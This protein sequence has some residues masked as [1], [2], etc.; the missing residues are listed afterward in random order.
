MFVKFLSLEGYD[1]EKEESFTD[2]DYNPTWSDIEDAICHMEIN[3]VNGLYLWAEADEEDC[4]TIGG[5]QFGKFIVEV[6]D[7]KRGMYYLINSSNS[8]SDE[9]ISLMACTQLGTYPL[10]I[11]VD[12]DTVIKA[13]KTYAELGICDPSLD[14]EKV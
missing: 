2:N 13:A 1:S 14:W 10:Q 6:N 11:C 9:K 7:T 5:G 4:M 12:L 8:K 3:E